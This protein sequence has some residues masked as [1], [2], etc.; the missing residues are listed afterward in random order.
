M[1]QHIE[2]LKQAVK[3][4]QRNL[5]QFE[6]DE[7][8]AEEQYMECLRE[9]YGDV[10]VCGM[11]MDA[12]SVLKYCDPTAFRCGMV[13]WMDSALRDNPEH[14]DGWAE[15]VAAVEEAEKALSDA[16]DEESEEE[17]AKP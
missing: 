5:N 10:E 11:R 7:R 14:F 9:T 1:N 3:T 15:A 2:T 8:Q 12:A 4:A 13:D 16:E 6:P 17:E